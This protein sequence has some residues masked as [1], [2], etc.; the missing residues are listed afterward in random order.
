MHNTIQNQK[1]TT[2]IQNLPQNFRIFESCA[3]CYGQT[4]PKIILK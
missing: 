2:T 4:L 1:N 3:S